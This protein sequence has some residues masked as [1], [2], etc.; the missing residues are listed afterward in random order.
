MEDKLKNYYTAASDQDILSIRK[1]KE[2]LNEVPEEK[3]D[4]EIV[5]VTK[6][7]N[8]LRGIPISNVI[9]DEDGKQLTI[10]D[11]VLR[12]KLRLE[13]LNAINAANATS[14][15]PVENSNESETKPSENLPTDVT[16]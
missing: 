14:E 3:L 6:M 12:N 13:A 8:D 15:T 2:I 1:F 9:M 4:N 11:F 7:G 16:K 5:I 10:F